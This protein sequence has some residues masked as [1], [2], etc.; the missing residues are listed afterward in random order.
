MKKLLAILLALMLVLVS[1]AALAGD[2]AN[3]NNQNGNGSANGDAKAAADANILAEQDPTA[4]ATY[5]NS[6]DANDPNNGKKIGNTAAPR[7]VTIKKAYKVTGST[8]VMPAHTLTFSVKE[9]KVEKN[10]SGATAFPTG[11]VT[12]SPVSVPANTADGAKL[13]F[14]INL[15]TYTEPGIYNYEITEDDGS[16][17]DTPH[18]VAGVEYLTKTY[19]L[20][21]TVVEG[22]ALAAGGITASGLVIG[23]VAL[24]EKGGSST[25]IDTIQ[26]E[27]IAGSVTV[28]KTV[29]GNMGDQK[30]P[31]SFS[32]VFKAG[33]K[34]VDAPITYTKTTYAADG[35]KST[36]NETIAAGWN[37]DH[38]AVTFQLIHGDTIT[39]NNVPKGVQYVVD[40]TDKNTNDYVTT[41]PTNATGTISDE[42]EVTV[43]FVND[44]SIPIDTGITLD[45]SAYILIMALALV[46]V[47]VLA[48][49]RREEY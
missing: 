13:D 10:T 34:Y 31:F 46:G 2:P 3:D 23:G 19:E 41:V 40:E 7:S 35:T 14:V 43:T 32:I 8:A 49:R 1:A 33:T 17:L 21:V 12:V 24:R 22:S 15:P 48:I 11:K 42:S 45:S 26:N 5:N 44:K 4:A 27:Y 47:T 36:T 9:I 29:T 39:F 30:R 20:K 16:K 37:G 28:G 18:T 6:S 25:K 38:A